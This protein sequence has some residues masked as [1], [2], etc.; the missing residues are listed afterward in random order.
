MSQTPIDQRHALNT[1]AALWAAMREM[2]SFTATELAHATRYNT[3]T[4][5]TYLQGL[6]AAG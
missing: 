4:V 3:S 5:Q 1:R 2:G 6:A